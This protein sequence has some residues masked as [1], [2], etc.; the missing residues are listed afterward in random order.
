[1]EVSMA[2][3][4]GA[5]VVPLG[6]VLG[7]FALLAV[8][9]AAPAQEV[10]YFYDA[11]HRLVGVMDPQGNAAE[12]RYD[13][14]G[15]LLQ[16]RRYTANPTTPVAILLVRPGDGTAHTPVEIYGKGFS[17]VPAENQVA[18]NGVAAVVTVATESTL[19]T[20][21]PAGAT[22]GPLTVTAP[23]GSATAPEPFTVLGGFLVVPDQADVALGAT[24]GFQATLDG[25]PTTAVT[26]RVNG[27]AGGSA[28]FGTITA[29]GVY[30]APA[31]PLPAPTVT[32]EAVRTDN[33]AWVA[34]ATVRQDQPGGTVAARPVSVGAPIGTAQAVA[35]GVSVSGPQAVG[36]QAVARPVAVA[37]TAL[38]GGLVV[39]PRVSVGPGVPLVG[40][41]VAVTR[42]PVILG[43]A[44]AAAPRG[45]T[46]LAVTL[47]GGNF[48]GAT[49]VRVLRD[50][51]ADPTL[52]VAGVTPAADG[53]S[54]T[55]TLTIGG[56]APLGAR[57][58]Q[59]VT[60]QGTSTAFDLGTNRFI[61]TV[62]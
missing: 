32:V 8:P 53:A 27:T 5:R 18:F 21:V 39:P 42:G 30:T 52:T 29:T 47:T 26:W 38:P 28:L 48:Q 49:A 58:V 44:P 41:R 14:V 55:L 6:L 12:Y 46:N 50:G 34:R 10:R 2:R 4:A 22:T 40:G 61:V 36:A 60:P 31:T 56:T 62:P 25:T 15:N 51:A 3:T 24:L 59:V 7:L 37:V 11:L 16:I 33:P 45:S 1:M 54:V 19:V 43:V 13:A 35:G 57:V 17:P 20:T 23:L 9:R